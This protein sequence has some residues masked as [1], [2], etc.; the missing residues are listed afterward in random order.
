MKGLTLLLVLAMA[1]PAMAQ[2][3]KVLPPLCLEAD[4]QLRLAQRLVQLEAE[5]QSLKAAPQGVPVAVLVAVAVVGAIGI[6][7]SAVVGYEAGRAAPR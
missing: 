5:V 1:S 4:A 3:S 7:A 6:G 2:D